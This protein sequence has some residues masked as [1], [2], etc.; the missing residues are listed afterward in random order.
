[1]DE[2]RDDKPWWVPDTQGF[3][4]IAIISLMALIVFI[5]L[6]R[7]P[8][9]DERTSGVLMTIVGVLIACLK[10]V[11]SF[12]FGSSRG[13][14]AKDDVLNKLASAPQAPLEPPPTTTITTVPTDST[15][16]P[17]TTTVTTADPKEIK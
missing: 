13:S 3:L 10:D 11:Y 15:T 16:T 14:A 17:T 12:F 4:A 5:L 6:T 9:I 1:M 8:Q 2:V 7:P